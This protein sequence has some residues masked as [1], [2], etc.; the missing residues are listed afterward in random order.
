MGNTLYKPNST[1]IKTDLNCNINSEIT[2]NCKVPLTKLIEDTFKKDPEIRK[3]VCCTGIGKKYIRLPAINDAGELDDTVIAINFTENDLNDPKFCSIDGT[4]YGWNEQNRGSYNSSFSYRKP[5]RYY[6]DETDNCVLF[7]KNSNKTGFCDKILN[8]TSYNPNF[9]GQDS[10]Y[11]SRGDSTE[12]PSEPKNINGMLKFNNYED[13]N[14]MNSILHQNNIPAYNKKDIMKNYTETLDPYSYDALCSLH[15]GQTFNDN[16]EGDQKIDCLNAIF[17]ENNTLT[18][19]NLN[20]VQTCKQ[21][22]GNYKNVH[23][24]QM[25]SEPVLPSVDKDDSPTIQQ[26]KKMSAKTSASQLDPQPDLQPEPTSPVSQ[27]SLSF[28]E[29]INQH[30]EYIGIGI[31]ILLMVLFLI[32]ELI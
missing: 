17:V 7:Y 14:C 30:P 13:C 21:D 28:S 5:D 1:G 27:E 9:K 31:I 24:N 18:N 12:Y 16:E 22:D 11:R 25:N 32:Y 6:L 29:L 26:M 8:N 3:R 20:E 19:S 4:N 10:G 23:D 2:E 15:Y